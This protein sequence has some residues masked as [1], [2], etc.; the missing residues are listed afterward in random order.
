MGFFAAKQGAMG[1]PNL[2][3]FDACH[4][5]VVETTSRTASSALETRGMDLRETRYIAIDLAMKIV[6]GRQDG[7]S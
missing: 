3:C 4:R 7:L 6:E 5:K 1:A 2:F